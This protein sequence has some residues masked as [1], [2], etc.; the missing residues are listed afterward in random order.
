MSNAQIMTFRLNWDARGQKRYTHQMMHNCVRHLAQI[1][2]YRDELIKIWVE[3]PSLIIWLGFWELGPVDYINEIWDQFA[4]TILL[5][6]STIGSD[7][8][9]FLKIYIFTV[10][11][12]FSVT[13]RWGPGI[14]QSVSVSE[15][16]ERLIVFRSAKRVDGWCSD[17]VLTDKLRCTDAPSLDLPILRF[18]ISVEAIAKNNALN[19]KLESNWFP[20]RKKHKFMMGILGIFGEIVWKWILRNL[21]SLFLKIVKINTNIIWDQENKS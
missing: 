17:D 10:C 11:L 2:I 5:S 13:C 7:A 1:Y 21:S 14:R 9:W 4:V 12:C 3:A 19:S 8:R 18:F 15:A 16:L 6:T 20:W